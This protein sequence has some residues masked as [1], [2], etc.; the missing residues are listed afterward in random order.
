M[1]EVRPLKLDNTPK[2]VYDMIILDS[3]GSMQSLKQT[4]LTGINAYIRKVKEDAKS[5]GLETKSS[6]IVF[7]SDVEVVYFNQGVEKLQEIPASDYIT[8]GGTSLNDAVAIGLTRLMKELEGKTNID[9]TV[10][11]FTDGEENTSSDYPDS[12]GQRNPDLVKLIEKA[13]NEFKWTIT[14]TG[15]GQRDAV[16]AVAASYSVPKGNTQSYNWGAAGA[17]DAFTQLRQSRSVRTSMLA[18]GLDTEAVSYFAPPAEPPVDP[19]YP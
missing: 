12:Y 6:L 4:T 16:Q 18:Q 13:Q 17:T 8:S 2:T 9:V 1:E 14:F 19:Q 15:A 11:I 7:N 3:S 10:N 5:S